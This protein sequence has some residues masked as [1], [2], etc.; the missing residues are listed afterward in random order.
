MKNLR[1][2]KRYSI[3]IQNG[4]FIYLFLLAAVY[5]ASQVLYFATTVE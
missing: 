2:I 4:I 3:L 5:L 1:K